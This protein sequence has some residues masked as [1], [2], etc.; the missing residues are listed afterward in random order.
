MPFPDMGIFFFFSPFVPFTNP[1]EKI[2]TRYN[3]R[4]ALKLNLSSTFVKNIKSFSL[5]TLPNT[6]SLFFT[7]THFGWFFQLPLATLH[8]HVKLPIP[9]ADTIQTFLTFTTQCPHSWTL[10]IRPFLVWPDQV[11]FQTRSLCNKSYMSACLDVSH[12]TEIK[13]TLSRYFT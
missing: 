6:Q 5:F 12:H 7:C 8:V 2:H 10:F 1:E 11:S 3:T 13:V 9:L 4:Y